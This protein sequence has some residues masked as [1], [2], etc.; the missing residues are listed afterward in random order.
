MCSL[1]N[2]NLVSD[3][4]HLRFS[5]LQLAETTLH[6]HMQLSAQC[7]AHRASSAWYVLF[8]LFSRP[9]F[10]NPTQVSLAPG[11]WL[12]GWACVSKYLQHSRS[13]ADQRTLHRCGESLAQASG[14]SIVRILIC[15][16]DL[17]RGEY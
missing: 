1:L 10:S 12:S 5:S 2:F 7:F 16:N 13:Q 4:I 14:Q 9:F 6:C 3:N 11:N 15:R 8:P 17:P